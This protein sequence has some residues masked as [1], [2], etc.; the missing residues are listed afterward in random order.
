MASH[1]PSIRLLPSSVKNPIVISEPEETVCESDTKRLFCVRELF[2]FSNILKIITKRLTLVMEISERYNHGYHIITSLAYKNINN[3][4]ATMISN[5]MF[6]S[7]SEKIDRKY[8]VNLN[9][10]YGPKNLDK[11]RF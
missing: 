10:Y 4:L 3:I 5:S 8:I 9:K 7:K 6:S 11:F 2:L 1:R